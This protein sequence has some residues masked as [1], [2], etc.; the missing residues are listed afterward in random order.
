MFRRYKK[1]LSLYLVVSI[2]LTQMIL[3]GTA[4]AAEAKKERIYGSG[5]V[6]TA[7][8]ISKAGWPDSS[9]YAVLVTAYNFPDAL[10]AAP[11]AKKHNAPLLLTEGSALNSNVKEELKRLNVK[12]VIIVGGPGVI[13]NAVFNSVKAIAGVERIYGAD[14]EETSVDVAKRIG[15]ATSAVLATGLDFPD[16]LSISSIAASKGMPIL[17]TGKN[18][19]SAKVEKYLK[20]NGITTTYIVGGT[21]VISQAVEAKAPGA[22]RLAG[23]SRVQTNYEIIKRFSSQF[24]FKKV[25]VATASDFPD[26]L[27]GSVLAAMTSSPIILAEGPILSDTNVI[28][29]EYIKEGSSVIALGGLSAVSDSVMANFVNYINGAVTTSS[30]KVETANTVNLNQIKLVYSN[31]VD[32]TSA[33]TPSNYRLGDTAFTNY[34]KITLQADGRTVDI[35]LDNPLSQQDNKVFLVRDKAVLS[36]DGKTSVSKY[37]KELSFFD[38]SSPSVKGVTVSGNSTL[39]IEFT[40]AIK[41]PTDL[42]NKI[43]SSFKLDGQYMANWSLSSASIV[44]GTTNNS[45]SNR[46]ELS[47]GAAIPPGNHVLSITESA[48]Q[49]LTDAAGFRVGSTSVS[50]TVDAVTNAPR[51]TNVTGEDNGIIYVTYDR[52]MDPSTAENVSKYSINNVVP[53]SAG[54]KADS[55][56]KIVRLVFAPNVVL[57]GSNVL[58]IS[59]DVKDTYGNFLSTDTNT[60]VA[61]NTSTDNTKPAVLSA[62]VIDNTHI[63]V[64]FSEAAENQYATG[65]GNYILQDSNGSILSYISTVYVDTASSFSDTFIL[66]LNTALTGDKYT[67]KIRNIADLART[68]NIMDDYTIELTWKDSEAPTITEEV[69]PA[70]SSSQV[71]VYFSEAMDRLSITNR[72]NLLY[73]DGDNAIHELPS[74]ATI[75]AGS[76]NKSVTITFPGAYRVKT[77]GWSGLYDVR[78]IVVSGVKDTAGNILLGV[79]GY[80][81][82]ISSSTAQN[83]PTYVENTFKLYSESDRVT[84]E[85]EF[86]E[87]IA[88]VYVTDFRVAG[89]IPDAAHLSGNKVILIFVD[90]DKMSMI[91][92]AGVTA[93]LS[94]AAT[95]SMNAAGASISSISA[96]AVYDDRIKPEVISISAFDS[97]SGYDLVKIRFSEAIDAI[98]ADSYKD[99][100][101]FTGGG[102]TIEPQYTTVSGE[103]V[104][105][106]FSSNSFSAGSRVIARALANNIHIRDA[107][108]T[109]GDYNIYIP[110]SSDISGINATA[111]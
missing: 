45:Y 53:V 103:Y 100:F 75:E 57:V 102:S 104:I 9:D 84:V 79:T 64:K 77:Y 39:T 51:V 94:T 32:R 69:A 56:N 4:S 96:K 42:A 98:I 88:T 25:Y 7:I 33:E 106:H 80:K 27:A 44:D 21:G 92:Q 43:R 111:R 52:A 3:T 74:S 70:G 50:F 105:Y 73:K 48:S 60:R 12:N 13:S 29:K 36:E 41:V 6:Q 78:G 87:A 91:K 1:I 17:L 49:Y 65:K 85:F 99:D 24:D 110:K 101:S 5:R 76:D 54:F 66:S 95:S 34:D 82:V 109:F 18:A 11:L 67:L 90:P 30:L 8:E 26:A 37:E 19:L 72:S 47:F 68:P 83:R 40:E 35:I 108:D 31:K 22:V 20:D 107:R 61:F 23:S 2:V 89:V 28:V 97:S 58:E 15:G 14:R 93:Q 55:G 81:D 86:S 46:I 63:R 62:S 38:T 16:A 10:C 71:T 59:Y